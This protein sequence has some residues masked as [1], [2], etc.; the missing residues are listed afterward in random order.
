M[1]HFFHLR[2]RGS[3]NILRRLLHMVM[4][5]LAGAWVGIATPSLPPPPQAGEGGQTAELEL[6]LE[7]Y[8]NGMSTQRI[9]CVRQTSAG[10]LLME[11]ETVRN[12]GLLPLTTAL[13][14]DGWMDLGLLP[15]VHARYEHTTQTLHVQASNAALMVRVLNAQELERP[16]LAPELPANP[17]QD[18]GAFINHTLYVST[19]GERWSDVRRYRNASA[20]L[21]ANLY[22]RFGALSSTQLIN[23]H[24]DHSDASRRSFRSV[25]LDTQ[26]AWFDE[27]RLMTASVGDVVSSNLSWSR[28]VR[29]GGVQ[30]R[31]NFTIRPDLITMPMLSEITGSAAVPS[32]VELYINNVQH[33]SQEV[34]PGPFAITNLPLITGAGTARL[35]VRDALGRETISETPFYASGHL[36]AQ[37]LSDFALDIGFARRNY[38]LLS[39]DYDNHL[40]ASALM[41]YGLTNAATLEGH[42]QA[43]GGL[44]LAGA[45]GVFRLGRFGAAGLAGALSRYSPRTGQHETGTQLAANLELEVSGIRF[46]ARH[47]HIGREFNDLASVTLRQDSTA[48]MRRNAGPP[49]RMSQMSLSFPGWSTPSLNLS[50]TPVTLADGTRSRLMGV[51]LGQRLPGNGWLSLSAYRDVERQN[52]TSVFVMLSWFFGNAINASTSQ[53]WN[54]GKLAT[55]TTDLSRSAR[56]EYG[57]IGWRMRATHGHGNIQSHTR[58]ASAS[59]RSRIG[60]FE[61][62]IEQMQRT[63]VNGRVQFDGAVVLAGG[64]VF[65]TNRIH[66]AFGVVNVGAPD[67]EVRYENTPYGRTNARGQLLLPTLRAYEHNLVSIDPME[68]PVDARIPVLRQT[69]RPRRKS[70][71]TINFDVTL[72]TRT[73]LLTV[74]DETGELLPMGAPATLNDTTV[75]VVGYDGQ[76]WLEE[77]ADM[78]RLR[79]QR[80][81]QPDCVVEFTAPATRG[82][83]LLLPDAICRSGQ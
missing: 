62:G 7:V 58:A 81:D 10:R 37:G 66:D 61:A 53:S 49:R 11:P 64:G 24:R 67:I 42:A 55:T 51:N 12:V 83:R 52:S 5:G 74:R 47:Q 1:F 31:R 63:G 27:N 17:V 77:V 71:M 3:K 4:A 14:E 34:A 19:G 40:L 15:G 8:I 21:E 59:Y 65:F 26:W 9:A 78:N 23:A 80:V 73:A 36:L 38:G 60:Y 2:E 35:V 16:T 25:R 68:L 82:E 28:A 13:H 72:H 76:I 69:V 56:N 18:S 29:L 75:T 22:G 44:A 30:I 43:G 48:L 57:S 32:T 45:G 20:M 6:H 41:R 39:D 50:W 46:H 70:G 54:A 33:W 79:V